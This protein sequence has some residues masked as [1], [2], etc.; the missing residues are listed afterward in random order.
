MNINAVLQA[1]INKKSFELN[2]NNGTIWC[3]HLDGMGAYEE[4]VIRKFLEDKSSFMRPSI[5]SY[6]I[7]NLDKTDISERIIETIVATLVGSGKTFRKIAFVGVDK[8]WHKKFCGIQENGC[9]ISFWEDY[10]KAK[11]WLI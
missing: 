5:S 8:R 10:E 6:I 7:I 1:G 2:Y 3:E 11:K 4:E 9:P